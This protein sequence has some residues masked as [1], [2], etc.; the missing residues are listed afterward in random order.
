M[1]F[2]PRVPAGGG[3]TPGLL[4]HSRPVRSD[5]M[6]GDAQRAHE[7]R[8]R[9]LRHEGKRV[10]ESVRLGCDPA[11]DRDRKPT[12]AGAAAPRLE[13][14][15]KVAGRVEQ[16][17]LAARGRDRPVHERNALG[18]DAGRARILEADPPRAARRMPADHPGLA[19]VD[20][21]VL[22]APGGEQ[23]DDPVGNVSLPDAVQR[24]AHAW[25]G[26]FEP[27]PERLMTDAGDGFGDGPRR[28]A[29]G[30]SGG[31]GEMSGL[32]IAER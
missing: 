29:V 22:H 5:K 3:G 7:L 16:G 19:H 1:A 26:E 6:R 11:L 21:R 2:A 20:Q 9:L 23:L 28:R 27:S 31:L 10:G 13:D 25:P 32:E 24:D 4:D 12:P 14:M 30:G 17:A 8:R 18:D 15:V